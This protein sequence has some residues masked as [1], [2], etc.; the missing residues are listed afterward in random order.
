MMS[1]LYMTSA[2]GTSDISGGHITIPPI[3][4]GV[5]E[6]HFYSGGYYSSSVASGSSIELLIQVPSDTYV[7]CM[8]EGAAGGDAVGYLYEGPTVSAAGTTVTCRNLNRA[9]LDSYN[10]T[11]T[12]TPTTTADGT[13]IAETFVPGGQYWVSSGA[14]EAL[15]VVLNASTDYLLRLTNTAGTSQP[16]QIRV[17]FAEM[18]DN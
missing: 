5:L 16:L 13:Q 18:I 17:A 6:G 3:L 2:A 14:T 12:H 9:Q 8:V 7:Q 11:V 1:K 4:S 15:P 10:V